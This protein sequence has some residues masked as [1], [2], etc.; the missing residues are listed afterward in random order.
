MELEALAGGVKC[1]GNLKPMLVV[2]MIKTDRDK[3]RVWLENFGYSVIPSGMNFV[4]IHK[5]DK[6]MADIKVAGPSPA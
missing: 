3:L 5:D 2:E 6:C 1:I 4:A